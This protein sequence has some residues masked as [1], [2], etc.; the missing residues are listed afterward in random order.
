MELKPTV[1]AVDNDHSTTNF[2][3]NLAEK[4]NLECKAHTSGLEFLET[5]DGG[6]PGCLILA[7]RIADIS[8]PQIQ[9]HLITRAID[10]PVIFVTGHATVPVIVRVMRE[11]ALSVLEK[12][13]VEQELWDKIQEALRL[14]NQQRQERQYAEQLK[15]RFA[16]VTAKEHMVLELL[17]EG[18]TNK[19]IAKE[20]EIA[21]RTVEL[22]RNGL[23][24]KLE[25]RSLVELVQIGMSVG[26]GFSLCPNP[27]LCSR[28]SR[29]PLYITGPNAK[30]SDQDWGNG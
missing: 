8:G 2:V 29:H 26:N 20:L 9:R 21:I 22:R 1:Y 13:I 14:D 7:V 19:D 10:I 18:K 27:H 25:A 24:K 17:L 5:F 16:A 30:L 23:M 11:G 4:M 6:K 12:P 3:R 28:Y 15:T